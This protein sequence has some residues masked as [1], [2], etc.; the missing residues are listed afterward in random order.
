MYSPHP[1]GTKYQNPASS[2]MMAQHILIVQINSSVPLLKYDMDKWTSHAVVQPNMD[3][4]C[5]SPPIFWSLRLHSCQPYLSSSLA[6]NSNSFVVFFSPSHCYH[7]NL[8]LNL[9]HNNKESVHL[10]ITETGEKIEQA[11]KPLLYW[12]ERRKGDTC[13]LM[14]I[15]FGPSDI[16]FCSSLQFL[17][18][19]PVL[20]S[21]DLLLS[22][23]IL[24]CTCMIEF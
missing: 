17:L 9:L 4:D 10:K 1:S 18:F 8:P 11:E 19:Y 20:F 6:V 14:L 21:Y 12:L 15:I 7:T 16:L 13:K 24:T 3:Y 23:D 2:T 5:F 22:Q